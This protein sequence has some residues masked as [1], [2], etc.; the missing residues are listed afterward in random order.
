MWPYIW[1]NRAFASGY[2]ENASSGHQCSCP[3]GSAMSQMKEM[4]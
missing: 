4:K 1:G 2:I 3:T